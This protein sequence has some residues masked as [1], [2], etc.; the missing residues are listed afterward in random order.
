MVVEATQKIATI[1]VEEFLAGE[2]QS[3]DRHEYLGGSVYAMAGASTTHNKIAG[4]VFASLR[5][6]LRGRPCEVF[7]SDVKLRLRISEEDVFYYP[8]LMVACDS[9]DTDAYFKSFPKVLI[10]ILSPQTEKTDRREKFL[11][12]LQI[13]SLEEYVLLAQ[14]KTEVTVFRRANKW[15]AEIFQKPD[16]QLRLPSLSFGLSLNQIYEG[17]K[18]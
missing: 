11:S 14:D 8:D 13:Q 2:L 10:E 1:S 9:R 16:E 15:Q 3:T 18:F 5:G 12:Y 17:I 4:N 6:H 7:I